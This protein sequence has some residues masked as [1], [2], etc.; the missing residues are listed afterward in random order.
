[1]SKYDPNSSSYLV[2]QGNDNYVQWS[3]FL[4][5]L[6]PRHWHLRVRQHCPCTVDQQHTQIGIASLI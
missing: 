4:Q 3:S 2:R 1:M 6:N 5:L